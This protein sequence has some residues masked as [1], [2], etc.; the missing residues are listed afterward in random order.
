MKIT[1]QIAIQSDEGQTAALQEV[2]CVER[3]A[4]RPDTLG[5]SLTEARLILTGL[6]QTMAEQQTADFVAQ[7]RRCPRC[8]RPRACKGHHR[9]VF[10]TPVRQAEPGQPAVVPLPL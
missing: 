5:L 3:G 6:E 7:A 1:V 8:G 10:R 4:L 9:I 2:A